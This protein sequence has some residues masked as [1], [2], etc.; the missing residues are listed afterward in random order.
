MNASRTASVLSEAFSRYLG[1]EVY[2]H[3]APDA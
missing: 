2:H 3:E 1:W